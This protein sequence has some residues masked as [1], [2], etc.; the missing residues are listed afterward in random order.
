MDLEKDKI[1]D[2]IIN[3][4]KGSQRAK[5]SSDLFE[6][7]LTDLDH[8]STKVISMNQWKTAIAAACFVL[9]F[10]LVALNYSY[11]QDRNTLIET[12]YEEDG[13][14]LIINSFQLY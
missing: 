2:K 1:M 5:P 4:M 12:L 14:P 11:Q 8:N 7:I 6:K 3:S 13:N 9:I 10:N